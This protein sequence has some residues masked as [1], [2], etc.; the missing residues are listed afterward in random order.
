M[1]P[2]EFDYLERPKQFGREDFWQQV[3]RTINGQPLSDDQIQLIV[4]QIAKGLSLDQSDKLL[5]IGCGNGALT[6]LLAPFAGEILGVDYSEYLIGIAQE[7]F[8]SPKLKFLELSIERMIEDKLNGSFGKALLYGVSSYLC[9]DLVE[10]LTA[11]Y[12]SR[13]GKSAMFIGNVR[14][15]RYAAEFYKEARGD[16]ELS[17]HTTSI[18]KWRTKEWFI[19]LG[20]RLELQVEFMKMPSMFYLSSYYFDVLFKR[21]ESA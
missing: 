10:R 19:E 4:Q 6:V 20:Q 1:K 18:G 16:Q 11:W 2:S 14:D 9:D 8:E 3:R 21:L 5:D 7:H 17:D 15:K 13:A 12:F